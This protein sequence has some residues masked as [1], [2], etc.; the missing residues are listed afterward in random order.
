MTAAAIA[1]RIVV[2]R[3]LGLDP[4][5]IDP[6][7]PLASYGLDSL[8]S[9]ELVAALEDA[10]GRSLPES[11]C[12]EHPTLSA[13][14]GALEGLATD[15]APWSADLELAADVTVA[16][17][18]PA[19]TPRHILLTG[20]TGLVGGYL[21]RALVDATDAQVWCLVRAPARQGLARVRANLERYGLWQ[22]V[23]A[24]RIEIVRGDLSA[25]RLGLADD[26]Y[27]SVATI[28]DAVIHA[29]A[30]VDWVQPYRVLRAANV[31]GTLELLR[32]AGASRP[33]PLQFISSLSVC[34]IPGGP[35]VVDETTDCLP[36]IDRLPLGYAQT[37]CVAERLCEG[38]HRRGLP[39]RVI[40][41]A[42]VAGDSRSGASNADDL[43]GRLVRGCID[44]H[45]APDLDWSFDAVPVDELARAVVAARWP[46]AGA[47]ERVHVSSPRPRSW[48]ECVLWLNLLG[49]RCRLTPFQEWR[50]HL[51]WVGR[52]SHHPLAPL[53]AF[54]R[55]DS[56]RDSPAERCQTSRHSRVIGSSPTRAVDAPMLARQVDA[57]VAAGVLRAPGR[58][59]RTVHATP[60]LWQRPGDLAAILRERF[61]ADLG[62]RG[63][64]LLENDAAL[65]IVS[66]LSSWRRGRQTGVFRV[67]ITI[68]RGGATTRL[69][70]VIKAR[71]H[72]TDVIEAAS[73]LA[74]ACDD[75]LEREVCRFEDAIGLK[76]AGDREVTLY[77]RA[78]DCLRRFMPACYGAWRQT[79]EAGAGLIIEDLRGCARLDA[80][81]PDAWTPADILAA[82]EGLAV[83]HAAGLDGAAG[84]LGVP[85]RR[86][87]D[88]VAMAP[89]WAAL[90]RHASAMFAR[91]GGPELPARHAA[92]VET[93]QQ[94]AP[95]LEASA[96]TLIHHDFNPRN[97]AIRT[98][99][100]GP[101]LVAYDWEL[102][103]VGLPQRDLAEFLC[104][105]LPPDVAASRV[106]E[107]VEGYRRLLERAS[108]RAWPRDAWQE[109]FRAAL[110][111]LLVDRLA[112]YAMIGRVRPQP[113]LPGVLR[114]WLRLD[115]IATSCAFRGLPR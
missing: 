55:D 64:E 106:T 97:A 47:F 100:T 48:Q 16:L 25:P 5:R 93:I 33:K 19:P 23:L 63:V 60:P 15:T 101:A 87:E 110:A 66:D 51:R 105:V 46:S 67:R 3:Q 91:A 21:L 74:S 14:A 12:F 53:Q 86:S 92:L 39:V 45:A 28:T 112:F 65:G 52:S 75:A 82:L 80:T 58:S 88:V 96:S 11:F 26:E 77:Q 89:L 40:R 78:P 49:Y 38:A 108:A 43:V 34:H 29:A 107:L 42:L 69:P 99:G 76:G 111:L 71:A 103:T 17:G 36:F 7:R 18:E 1:S 83:M 114:T 95:S 102:A 57:Y 109:G 90:A 10:T 59:R 24:K 31:I 20:A 115:A 81:T 30:D 44:M 98:D 22:E 68:E 79:D 113:F 35:P 85:L 41:P 94:W 27:S 56:E 4:D 37:K 84:C 13:L 2:A 9:L 62:V 8:R 73:G 61:G 70:A 32:I 54:F 6:D 50:E 72:D 104:F